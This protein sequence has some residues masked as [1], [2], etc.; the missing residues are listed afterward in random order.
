MKLIKLA[1]KKN[2]A[3]AMVEFAI[4]LPILLLLLYGVLEVGRLLFMYSTIVTASRQASRYGATTGAGTGGAPRYQDCAGIR[5]AANRVD[6][7]SAFDHLGA[8][9]DIV[10]DSGDPDTSDDFDEC[11]VMPSDNGVNPGSANTT[12]IIVTVRGQF[13]PLVPLIPLP[14]RTITAESAR[15]ILT[16]VTIAV[17]NTPAEATTT[18]IVTNPN[19]SE[20]GQ[21]VTATVTVT[22]VSGTGTPT[23]TVDVAYSGGTLCTITLSGGTGSCGLTFNSTTLVAA[24]YIPD[25][26][27]FTGSVGSVNHVVGPSTTQTLVEDTDDPSVVGEPVT[28]RITVSNVYGA[29]PVPAGTVDVTTAAGDCTITLN[30]AGKGNCVVTYNSLGTTI[31]NA[32]FNPANPLLHKTSDGMSPH[33]VL[34]GTATPSLTPPPPTPTNTSPPPTPTF[35][36]T[37]QPTPVTGCTNIQVPTGQTIVLSTYTM[38]LNIYNPMSYDVTVKDVFVRWNYL[39][40]HNPGD[41]NLHLLS[42]QI[43]STLGTTIFWTGDIHAPS[44]S[45]PLSTAVVIPANST[46]RI[47]FTFDK[48]Y[49]KSDNEQ[50]QISFSTPGCEDHTINVVKTK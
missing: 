24:T 23:G 28:I 26:S 8:D 31:I 46:S 15:T 39:K 14:A 1:P 20:P 37:I 32:T 9:V 3:Q 6:Y 22:P 38:Y 13:T 49:T 41:S 43:N 18:L 5:E 10:Y 19:P 36:P 50:I 48:T 44:Y 17:P 34:E 11:D 25:T 27:D 7:L 21:P 40:G 47:V 4:V 16:S 45:P 35:T 29:G 33:E 12:R 42:A 30:S 2:V